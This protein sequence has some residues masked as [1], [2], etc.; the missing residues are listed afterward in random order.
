MAA[1]IVVAALSA[2][3]SSLASSPKYVGKPVPTHQGYVVTNSIRHMLPQSRLLQGG[4]R[5]NDEGIKVFG[6]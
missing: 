3:R 5:Q 6:G 1:V 4:D 2:V